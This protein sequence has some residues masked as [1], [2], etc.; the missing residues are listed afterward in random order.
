MELLS[1]RKC[2][3]FFSVYFD[4]E[5]E[6]PEKIRVREH[7]NHCPI[8]AAEWREFKETVHFVHGMDVLSAPPDL[9]PGINTAL[10][11]PGLLARLGGWLAFSRPQTVFA[12]IAATLVVGIVTA[13]LFYLPAGPPAQGVNLARNKA[14]GT[15]HATDRAAA[16]VPAAKNGP[17]NFYPGI[18]SLAQYN[19]DNFS[20]FSTPPSLVRT[21]KLV[22]ARPELLVSLV[23]TGGNGNYS[24]TSLLSGFPGAKPNAVPPRPDVIITVKDDHGQGEFFRQ[25]AGSGKWQ[26]ETG[27]DK[28]LLLSMP[29]SRLAALRHDL[30]RQRLSYV[31]MSLPGIPKKTLLV[32]IKLQH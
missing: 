27:R 32:A 15:D 25:L 20:N 7:L 16:E 31:Q 29:P 23:S 13:S 5:L 2:R 3:D 24:G 12:T 6:D 17:D 11:R 1:C 28:L 14:I 22:Q 19:P 4:E 30:E 21:A 9:L 8:C 26:C 10:A 18:P